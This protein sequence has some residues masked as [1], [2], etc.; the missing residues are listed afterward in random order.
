M[1]IEDYKDFVK[2]ERDSYFSNDKPYD[3]IYR[4]FENSG[5]TKKTADYFYQNASN[6]IEII[7]KKSWKEFQNKEHQ[8]TSKMLSSLYSEKDVEKKTSSEAISWFVEKF[9]VHI[10]NL[11]LS[12]TQS[13]RS[14][15]GKEF[16]AIIELILIGSDI[17]MDSQGNIG[18][19]F[20]VNKGLGKLVDIVSPG[21]I[22]YVLNKRDTVLI[23]AKTTLRERWQEVPEEMGRTGAR[24]MFLVTLDDTISQEVIENLND[25]NIQIVVTKTIKEQ[26]YKSNHSVI[27]FEKLLSIL[28]ETAL[29]WDDF[30]YSEESKKEIKQSLQK[31][32]EKHKTHSFVSDYY[33]R[34]LAKFN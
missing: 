7:R 27:S 3:F 23:S 25:N 22:E 10:Y 29:R 15:A 4:Q 24:E 19:K 9:P 14:R 8:F 1:N 12:N 13:R 30:N 31:Q 20:F 21:S 28:K 2:K 16:E 17:P 18:K 33:Q 6:I 32:L 26:R 34:Y 11:N 5:F